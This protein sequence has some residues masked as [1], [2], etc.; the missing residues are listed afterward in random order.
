MYVITLY[1]I[2]YIEIIGILFRIFLV[3]W[4]EVRNGKF[5][6]R[7]NINLIKCFCKIKNLCALGEALGNIQEYE[8][9]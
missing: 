4:Q 5:E 6:H 1:Y 8:Y 9:G 3:L 2:I 7:L